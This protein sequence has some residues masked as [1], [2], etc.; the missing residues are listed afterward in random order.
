MNKN[1]K[2]IICDNTIKN[3]TFR[4]NCAKTFKEISFE[5]T[6]LGPPQKNG[7][8]ERGDATRYS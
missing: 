5:L 8:I 1:I 2:I 7:V 6:L 3:K 4:E